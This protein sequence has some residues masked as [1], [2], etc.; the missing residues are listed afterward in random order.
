MLFH[1]GIC[2]SDRWGLVECSWRTKAIP[3]G[4]VSV[5]AASNVAADRG[6][7]RASA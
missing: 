4:C 6:G 5:K 2:V 7:I 3:I 1:T